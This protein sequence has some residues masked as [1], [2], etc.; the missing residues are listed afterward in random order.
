M[1]LVDSVPAQVELLEEVAAA[2]RPDVIVADP[3]GYA[4]PIVAHRRG[5]P[6]SGVSTL[7]N[8]VVPDDWTSELIE[9]TRH[10]LATSCSS[11]TGSARSSASA[12]AC[13]PT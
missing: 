9:T 4:A 8:P 6:G 1:M 7:L 12:T 11:A 5:F 13:H 2:F 10:C 3:M